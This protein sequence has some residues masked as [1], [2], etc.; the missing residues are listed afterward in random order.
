MPGVEAHH[1]AIL[2]ALAPAG[3][4]ERLRIKLSHGYTAIQV[5][6]R[7]A[8]A[9][10]EALAGGQAHPELARRQALDAV[11]AA[12]RQLAS[13]GRVIRARVRL[14]VDFRVKGARLIEVDVFRL[15]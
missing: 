5:M 12:L 14:R 11:G 13:D 10:R 7:L 8:P 6:E 4:S 1:D 2:R 3:L 9:N 15:P